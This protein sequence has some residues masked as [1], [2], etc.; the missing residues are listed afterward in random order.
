[1]GL[2][3]PPL[4]IGTAPL[5]HN[6]DAVV[7]WGPIS[8]LGAAPLGGLLAQRAV[9]RP[10]IVVENMRGVRPSTFRVPVPRC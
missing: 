2:L 6:F 8:V 3:S 7:R 9:R 10:A 4:R 1:M 5:R